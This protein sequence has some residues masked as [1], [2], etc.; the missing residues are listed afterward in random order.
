MTNRLK[1]K[2]TYTIFSLIAA[3]VLFSAGSHLGFN[4]IPEWIEIIS[5]VAAVVFLPAV[6]QLLANLLPN[7]IKCKL[8]FLRWK[9]EMPGSRAHKLCETDPRINVENASRVWPKLFCANTTEKDRNRIWYQDIYRLVQDTPQVY[10]S[11][12][13][14]LLYRDAF[15]G[16]FI[17]FCTSVLFYLF[18]IELGGTGELAIEAVLALAFSTALAMIVARNMGNRFVVNAIAVAL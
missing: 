3:A 12:G 7:Q 1:R 18:K 15:A 16:L 2:N 5:A 8:I 13:S 17:L 10:Q 11:H 6:A 14:F 4:Q 9:N